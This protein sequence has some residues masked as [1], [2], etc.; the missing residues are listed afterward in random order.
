VY[1]GELICLL[2]EQANGGVLEVNEQ[3]P[4]WT[5]LIKEVPIRLPSAK[6]YPVWFTEVAFPAFSVSPT[7]IFVRE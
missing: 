4:G 6:P 2:I 5:D 7:S 1:S 3:M